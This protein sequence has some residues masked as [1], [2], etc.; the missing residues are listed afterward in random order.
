MSPQSAPGKE[1][2]EGC[3]SKRDGATVSGVNSKKK[4][5]ARE[6][7]GLGI[8]PRLPEKGAVDFHVSIPV[9]V[10]RIYQ[11]QLGW[12]RR[13]GKYNAAPSVRKNFVRT[14]RITIH[15]DFPILG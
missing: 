11:A 2:C 4:A 14:R 15:E 3:L 7:A 6:V 8:D 10:L 12:R 9:F 13:W 1:K 5:L